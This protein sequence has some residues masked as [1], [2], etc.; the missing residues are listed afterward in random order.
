MGLDEQQVA[1]HIEIHQ[2]SQ[3]QAAQREAEI[4]NACTAE[5]CNRPSPKK[6]TFDNRVIDDIEPSEDAKEKS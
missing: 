4:A 1:K 3:A 6:K 2:A 5:I